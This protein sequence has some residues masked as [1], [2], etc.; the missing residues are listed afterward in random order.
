M[1]SQRCHHCGNFGHKKYECTNK[2]RVGCKWCDKP[3]SRRPNSASHTSHRNS[4]ETQRQPS[5][6]VNMQRNHGSTGNYFYICS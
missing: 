3:P 1:E 6:A 2:C 4:I 5:S